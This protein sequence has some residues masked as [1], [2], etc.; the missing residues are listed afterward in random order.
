MSAAYYFES[1]SSSVRAAHVATLPRAR[2]L[3]VHAARVRG[4]CVVLVTRGQYAR[5]HEFGRLAI[6]LC[7]RVG[8]RTE[9]AKVL[10]IVAAWSKPWCEPLL[11]SVQ[12]CALAYC[13]RVRTGEFQYAGIGRHFASIICSP[14]RAAR[15]RARAN[16]ACQAFLRQSRPT[17]A[18]RS[19]VP[20][21]QAVRVLKG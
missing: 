11:K 8:N 6:E 21:R 16:R 9:E 10:F 13:A 7:A 15:H 14:G 3:G 18:N 17:P 2:L 19:A 4:L 5:A 1:R 12:H 20:Y